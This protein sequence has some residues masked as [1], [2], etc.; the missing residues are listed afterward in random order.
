MSSTQNFSVHS[1]HREGICFYFMDYNEMQYLVFP[2]MCMWGVMLMF[3]AAPFSVVS[4]SPLMNHSNTGS[5]PRNLA[6]TLQDIETKR[7]LALQQKG[8]AYLFGA[9][10]PIMQR[11]LICVSCPA[12]ALGTDTDL[13]SPQRVCWLKN[14]LQD[15][16]TEQY[17]KGSCRTSLQM[18]TI[19]SS[20]W[21]TI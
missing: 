20:T 17:A 6:A 12:W 3:C 10:Y 5:L 21:I 19:T 15:Q 9:S 4:Q 14:M 7:Q 1:I 16:E 11:P 8:R 13:C 2:R 18:H